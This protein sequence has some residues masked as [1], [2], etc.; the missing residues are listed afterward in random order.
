[1]KLIVTIAAFFLF[2]LDVRCVTLDEFEMERQL[3]FR[4]PNGF[5]GIEQYSWQ[6]STGRVVQSSIAIGQWHYR[7][8]YRIDALLCFPVIAVLMLLLLLASRV[9]RYL[10][11]EVR[12]IYLAE[13]SRSSQL[14]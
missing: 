2:C 4:G 10:G 7:F 5:Y 14:E 12:K 9:T 11:R 8:S 1:M 13:Q 6:T 3:L